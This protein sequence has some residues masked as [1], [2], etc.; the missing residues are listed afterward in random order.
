[1][2]LGVILLVIV[3][4]MLLGVLPIW[5]HSSDWSYRPTGAVSVIVVVVVVLLVM[6]RI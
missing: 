4:L 3:V 2:S 6:G 1:M 5:S